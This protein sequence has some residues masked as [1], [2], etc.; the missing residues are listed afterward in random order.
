VNDTVT[1]SLA[2]GSF[3]SNAGIQNTLKEILLTVA[4]KSPNMIYD[5]Q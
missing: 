3:S 5:E 2:G 1:L 4:A